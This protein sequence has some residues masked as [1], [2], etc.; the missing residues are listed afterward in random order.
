MEQ[1][2]YNQQPETVVAI[3]EI[4]SHLACTAERINITLPNGVTIR[5]RKNARVLRYVNLVKNLILKTHTGKGLCFS[6]HG[7][8]K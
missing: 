2:E 6:C 1:D 8:M 5:E 3:D 4:S 7:E